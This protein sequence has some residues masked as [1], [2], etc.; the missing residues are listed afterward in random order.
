[1][2]LVEVL[3]KGCAP[4]LGTVASSFAARGSF[5]CGS[6]ASLAPDRGLLRLRHRGP[7]ARTFAFPLGARFPL[8]RTF[9]KI[10]NIS[11]VQSIMRG[12]Q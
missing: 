10:N 1:M 8:L 12:V 11:A 5:A 3:D 7:F 4:L 2:S 6:S 9:A